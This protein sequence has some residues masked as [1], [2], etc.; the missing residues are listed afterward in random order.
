[1]FATLALICNFKVILLFN[2]NFNTVLWFYKVI[3]AMSH[4]LL[5]LHD[6]HIFIFIFSS[7]LYTLYRLNNYKQE[8]IILGI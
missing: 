3:L 5:E 8:S 2:Y 4:T 1:M 7:P 6:L